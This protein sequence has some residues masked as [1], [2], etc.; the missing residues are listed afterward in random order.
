MT[1]GTVT[2]LDSFSEAK[3]LVAALL[4]HRSRLRDNQRDFVESLVIKFEKY[5]DNAFISEA[6]LN[7][8]RELQ[9][10]LPDDRQESLFEVL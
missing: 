4:P 6:Q 1:T 2:K 7:W 5:G 10:H 3:L 8:L 9:K